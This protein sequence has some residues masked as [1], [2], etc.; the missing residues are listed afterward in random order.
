MPLIA[1]YRTVIRYLTFITTLDGLLFETF[2]DPAA[3]LQCETKPD[4]LGLQ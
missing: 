4:R 1:Y 2:M 3:C